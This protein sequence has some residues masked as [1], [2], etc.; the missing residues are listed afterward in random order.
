MATLNPVGVVPIPAES[1][2]RSLRDTLHA[3]PCIRVIEAH[4]AMCAILADSVGIEHDAQRIEYDALWSG[5]LTDAAA[6]GK[7]D[8]GV[9]DIRYRLSN[10]DDILDVT[11]RPMI[12]DADSGGYA[13][14]FSINVRTLERHGV[15][16]VII[17]DKVG[18]KKNSL[19]GTSAEQA[20]ESIPAFCDKIARGKAAQ[21]A[22]DFMII[23]RV[24]SLVLDAGM[25]DALRRA[26]AYVEA[27]A[28]GVMIHTNR[29]QPDEILDFAARFRASHPGV[30][31]VCV[32]TRLADVPFDEFARHRFNVVIYA[33]QLLRAAYPAMREVALSILREGRTLAVE[34]QCMP[35]EDILNLIPGTR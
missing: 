18:L 29:A 13:E 30:P 16:A 17:E 11:T 15:S 8:T 33:N 14:H 3:K 31:L 1:R 34:A 27:G 12:V 2:R 6:R 20:Q 5:S 28:D 22:A 10:I 32:P 9:L 21:A 4:S 26:C 24:E 7:P 25:D 23:A 35:V 19:L